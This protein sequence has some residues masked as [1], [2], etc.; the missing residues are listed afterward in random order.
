MGVLLGPFRISLSDG[1]TST[2]RQRIRQVPTRLHHRD[3]LVGSASSRREITARQGNLGDEPTVELS[4]PMKATQM[5]PRRLARFRS[6]RNVTRGKVRD[7]ELDVDSTDVDIAEFC[8]RLNRPLGGD[9]GRIRVALMSECLRQD[10][11]G[12]DPRKPVV[13]GLSLGYHPAQ[14]RYGS[15]QITLD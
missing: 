1:H 11:Q 10:E 8:G 15:G 5:G 4:C 3:G 6:Q 2:R 13:L 9:S 7:H 14:Q 12:S